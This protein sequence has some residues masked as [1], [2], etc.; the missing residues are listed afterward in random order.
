MNSADTQNIMDAT[1]YRRYSALDSPTSEKVLFQGKQLYY[2]YFASHRSENQ[3][4][5]ES[6][7][8]FGSKF[9]P[10]RV[11][12]IVEGLCPLGKETESHEFCSPLCI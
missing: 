4:I 7:Y 1:P 10:L 5:K 3:L 8:S 12:P 11:D 2:F 6:I 9:L